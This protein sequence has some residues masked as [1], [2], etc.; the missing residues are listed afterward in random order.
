[1]KL[2]RRQKERL[3]EYCFSCGTKYSEKDVDGG[4]CTI[5]G[6]SIV[7]AVTETIMAEFEALSPE[8]RVRI[9][10]QIN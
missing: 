6:T 5:C 2:T 7:G 1:M 4:R 10:R 8:M 3:G 9:L